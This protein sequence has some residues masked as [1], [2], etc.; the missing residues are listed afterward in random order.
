MRG[1]GTIHGL[2]YR[3]SDNTAILP[4]PMRKLPTKL[5]QS[6]QVRELDRIA[7]QEYGIAGISLMQKAANAVWKQIR[8]RW[9]TVTQISVF[10]G[11]GNNAGDGYL[12]AVLAL[13]AGLKVDVYSMTEVD[14]LSGYALMAYQTYQ[15]A[16]G[17]VEDFSLP[18]K[19][20]PELIVDALLGTGLVRDVSGCYAEVVETIN[21]CD[22]PVVAVDIPSGLNADTGKIM[23]CAVQADVT[24]TFIALK[25]GLFTADGT[26]CCGDC[27]FADL[28]V[29]DEIFTTV[30]HS[31][32]RLVKTVLPHRQRNSHKGSYGHVLVIGGELGFS[33]AVRLAAEAALRSGAGLV[34][35][36]TRAAHASVINAGRFELMCHAV[37][38]VAQLKPLLNKATVLVLGTGLGQQV[39]G[40]DLFEIVIQQP[41]P[42]VIDADGLNLLA[43]YPCY[44]DNRVLT[45]HPGEAARL[46]NCTTAEIAADRFAAVRQI[47]ATYGG[48]CVLKGAGTLIFDGE[49]L[50]VSTTG[51][52]GMAS[53]GM[54]DVLAGMIGGLLAQ[55]FSVKQA[56]KIGV[57]LHGAAADLAAEQGERGLL[58]S[59]LMPMIRRLVN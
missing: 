9:S 22:C 19:Q 1:V 41:Q 54:G 35:V 13:K 49:E 5:Y 18:L 6:Q 53:G 23:G 17:R 14:K 57:Y 24:V 29:P 26:E 56:A 42:L 51:N 27:V 52:P 28:A 43:S 30:P 48:V 58:A 44:H 34:S 32:E 37:E 39:W 15:Q 46:L 59:D 3:F 45:P 38:Q 55:G 16:G 21:S 40:H 8:E 36:A 25:Q 2:Q 7:I 31:A 50:F 20:P 47:Q 12:V 10:C 11:T 4:K 33:G